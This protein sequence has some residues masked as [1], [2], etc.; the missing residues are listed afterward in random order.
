MRPPALITV[1]DSSGDA[2][3]HLA[4][5]GSAVLWAAGGLLV[6]AL[7]ASGWSALDIPT[8]RAALALVLLATFVGLFRPA[9]LR[10]NRSDVKYLLLAGVLGPG[11]TGPLYVYCVLGAPLGVAVLLGYTAPVYAAI[12]AWPLLG[13]RPDRRKLLAL[14]LVTAG[15]V[16]VTGL[17]G[18]EPGGG[19]LP[20]GAVAAGLGTG[21]TYALY[22]LFTRRLA[23]SCSPAGMQVWKLA[24]GLP[25]LLVI[26]AFWPASGATPV[27][28]PLTVG[29]LVAFVVGPYTIGHLLVNW[30]LA[31]V[32][33]G[34]ASILLTVEPVVAMALGWA[35]L[36][37]RL[38]PLQLAGMGLVLTAI[39]LV[40]ARQAAGR[41][42]PP[43]PAG[44]VR[45]H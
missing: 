34:P 12:L 11:L 9:E 37:E 35:V 7:G 27:L 28:S 16:L 41:T 24:G 32:Q 13:E 45:P 21:L 15:L 31:R 42:A 44:A 33:A 5:V 3:R 26:R 39:W 6:R 23:A 22:L 40:S 10:V 8:A 38:E 30:G 18:P 17:L 1:P 43:P 36:G 4:L 14:A 29:M 2:A 20:A 25:V 19:P